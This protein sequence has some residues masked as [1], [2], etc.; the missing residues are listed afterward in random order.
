[1]LTRKSWDEQFIKQFIKEQAAILIWALICCTEKK[2]DANRSIITAADSN[3]TAEAAWYAYHN[4]ID[5]AK[6]KTLS[7]I[8]R[9]LFFDL[10]GHG[11]TIQRLELGDS[12]EAN[13]LKIIQLSD[14]HLKKKQGLHKSLARRINKEMPD[15]LVIT[16]DAI[17]SNAGLA[18]LDDVLGLIDRAIP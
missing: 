16:G 11:H 5:S 12:N 1:M 2:L 14:L 4:F 10:N 9:G 13:P 17:E 15:L 8:G 6:A 18:L 3:A 7:Q